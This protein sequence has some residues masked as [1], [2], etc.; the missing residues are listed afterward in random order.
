M[1]CAILLLFQIP[2]LEVQV[3]TFILFS[4]F[5]A[6]LFS[7]M[8]YFSV[9]R[10]GPINSGKLYGLMMSIAG[11]FTF[12]NYPMVLVVN[13]YW[14]G[15]YFYYNLSLCLFLVPLLLAVHCLLRPVV[16][17]LQDICLVAAAAA[18]ASTQQQQ[19]EEEERKGE[20]V[21]VVFVPTAAGSA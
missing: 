8:A 5:R 3:V 1:Q 15:D 10:F 9:H 13:E 7:V 17:K 6:F 2:V 19:E 18:S 14:G 20:G 16:G 21:E 12:L 4:F 11:S